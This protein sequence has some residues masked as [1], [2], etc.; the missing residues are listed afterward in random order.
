MED[1]RSL[2]KDLRSYSVYLIRRSANS[3][4]HAL[5]REAGS[6][7]DHKEWCDLPSFLFDVLMLDLI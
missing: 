6:L 3:V 7:S 5:A 2:I 1:C 4:A